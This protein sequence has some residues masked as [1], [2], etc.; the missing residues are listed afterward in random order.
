MPCLLHGA[1]HDRVD[2][3]KR[4]HG[5][6]TDPHGFRWYGEEHQREQKIGEGQACVAECEEARTRGVETRGCDECRDK[7]DEPPCEGDQGK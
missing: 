3:Q 5:Y 1:Q 6:A 7:Q 2:Q 4:S